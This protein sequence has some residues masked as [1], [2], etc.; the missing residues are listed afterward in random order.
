MNIGIQSSLNT[1][2]SFF[3]NLLY[4][5]LFS[6]MPNNN[7]TDAEDTSTVA[8]D[9]RATSC[10]QEN[11]GSL[12][13]FNVNPCAKFEIDVSKAFL[14][15]N[16]TNFSN[17]EMTGK[18]IK[19]LISFQNEQEKILKK[20]KKTIKLKNKVGSLLNK[21]IDHEFNGRFEKVLIKDEFCLYY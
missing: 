1:S 15:P 12:N 7:S 11:W 8:P 2:T 5:E 10:N 16:K 3:E 21:E 14:K 13:Q 18:D 20:P 4:K 17:N 9:S 19:N 6:D